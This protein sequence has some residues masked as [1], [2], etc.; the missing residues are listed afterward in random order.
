MNIHGTI[1][2]LGLLAPLLG[3]DTRSAN[4]ERE[5][6]YGVELGGK[7]CG[8]SR[9]RISKLE[10]DGRELLLLEQRFY[11]MLSLLGAEFDSQLDLTYHLDPTSGGFLYHDSHILQGEVEMSMALHVENGRAR[12]TIPGTDVEEFI[13]LPPGTILPNTF[14][15]PYV[16]ADFADGET[17]EKTYDVYDVRDGKVGPVK[18]TKVGAERLTLA[19][20]EYDALVLVE[21]NASTGMRVRRWIDRASGE[22]L[23]TVQPNGMTITR[24]EPSVL[25]RIELVNIDQNIL[26]P[27]DE[28]IP[29]FRRIRHLRVR[30]ILEPTG[31]RPTPEGLNIPGQ[32]FE[33]SVE[34]N[35]IE[36]TFEISHPIYDGRGAPPFPAD[37]S[38]R[39]YLAPYLAAEDFIEADDPVLVEAAHGMV[40]GATDSW[41]AARGISHWVTD[42]I[43]GALP[44]GMTARR[45]CDIRN[46][47]CGAHSFLTAALCRAVGIPA[48][49]VWGCMYLPMNGGCFGQHVW[50][51]VYMGEAGWIPVDTRVQEPDFIDSGHLRI[52]I[53]QSRA[54]ALNGRSFEILEHSVASD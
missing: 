31:L 49:A 19:G 23:K 22:L 50:N 16:R 51:E 47:E 6:T 44:G 15:F 13:E 38:G 12:M 36:G 32:S 33:G 35:R 5:L 41:D 54:T 40:E 48:R 52:G 21:E 24:A 37:W 26:T 27:T 28:S 10:E 4:E 39:E 30:A 53:F 3:N 20:V 42:N 43:H 2:A 8:Y 25:E 1:L 46:G 18:W 45:T 7:L 9:L 34:Q 14:F 29:A 11:V 17:R